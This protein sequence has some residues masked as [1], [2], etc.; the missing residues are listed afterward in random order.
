MIEYVRIHFTDHNGTRRHEWAKV[1]RRNKLLN[2]LLVTV[3]ELV[4]KDGDERYINTITLAML[5]PTS[6]TEQPAQM[7]LKYAWLEICD[8][9]Q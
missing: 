6:V 2:G 9:N 7:N 8:S 4:K 3:Y 5:Q 1:V